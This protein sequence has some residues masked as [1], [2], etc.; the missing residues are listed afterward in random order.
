MPRSHT[1]SPFKRAETANPQQPVTLNPVPPKYGGTVCS[2]RGVSAA[3]AREFKKSARVSCHEPFR[4]TVFAFSQDLHSW[5][6]PN[7]NARMLR[8]RRTMLRRS[9]GRA[10]LHRRK[11]VPYEDSISRA[12]AL[13]A[14]P[15]ETLQRMLCYTVLNGAYEDVS[16]LLQMGVPPP[17]HDT[18]DDVDGTLL[19][20]A[21]V[22][23]DD[24]VAS[25]LYI[26]GAS[27]FSPKSLRDHGL[28]DCDIEEQ[29]KILC[30]VLEWRGDVDVDPVLARWLRHLP[31]RF[32]LE[33]ASHRFLAAHGTTD[34]LPQLAPGTDASV[35]PTYLPV[36]P[37]PPSGAPYS[38]LCLEALYDFRQGVR[39][40]RWA[41]AKHSARHH[42]R[43]LRRWARMRSAA[44]YWF[45]RMVER[46][47]GPGGARRAADRRAYRRDFD[48]RRPASKRRM[49]DGGVSEDEATQPAFRLYRYHSPP[50]AYSPTSPAYSPTHSSYSPSA[51]TYSPSYLPASPS[52]NAFDWADVHAS[53]DDAHLDAMEGGTFTP[54]HSPTWS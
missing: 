48:W 20:H 2:E 45:G 1:A 24:F 36:P 32:T 16:Y 29:G 23:G 52:G 19:Y 6:A 33:V 35:A 50:P 22:N 42:W 18:W 44:F 3:F 41:W 12:E 10:H 27:F 47:C 28:P 53:D 54:V 13:L 46:T 17:N 43:T 30:A 51:P 25:L 4:G 14:A 31:P 5:P 49:L 21:V 11:P 9:E 37:P 39:G 26:Y 7:A 38:R 40:L 15:L 34:L 8:R